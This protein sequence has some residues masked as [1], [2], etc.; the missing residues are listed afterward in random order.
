MICM[1]GKGRGVH[2][3]SGPGTITLRSVLREGNQ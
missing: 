1:K 3:E 2:S